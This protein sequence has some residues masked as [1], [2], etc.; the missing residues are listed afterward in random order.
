MLLLA[1][2]SEVNDVLVSFADTKQLFG[3]KPMERGNQLP[4]GAAALLA[5]AIAD[6]LWTQAQKRAAQPQALSATDLLSA[7]GMQ[8]SAAIQSTLNDAAPVALSAAWGN[9]AKSGLSES[10][11]DVAQSVAESMG[12]PWL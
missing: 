10:A 12:K 3:A 6:N 9:L 8:A 5:I 2:H 4:F 1:L 11:N 7:S